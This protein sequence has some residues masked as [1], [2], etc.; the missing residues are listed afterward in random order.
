ML[1]HPMPPPPPGCVLESPR[2]KEIEAFMWRLADRDEIPARWQDR[3][4]WEMPSAH[5][6][7]MNMLRSVYCVRTIQHAVESGGGGELMGEQFAE[8][9]AEHNDVANYLGWVEVAMFQIHSHHHAEGE[10]RATKGRHGRHLNGVESFVFPMMAAGAGDVRRPSM[11]DR[12]PAH[13]C[14]TVYWPM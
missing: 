9:A 12:R 11:H 6:I 4:Q 3:W 1:G 13:R 10:C 2:I 14:R 7:F 5:V 8:Y